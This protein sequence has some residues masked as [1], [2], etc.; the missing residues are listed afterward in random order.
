MPVIPDVDISFDIG[1]GAGLAVCVG[2]S[3]TLISSHPPHN[4]QAHY[5][6]K[7]DHIIAQNTSSAR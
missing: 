7:T 5:G 1:I 2:L 3:F 6:N 4:Q